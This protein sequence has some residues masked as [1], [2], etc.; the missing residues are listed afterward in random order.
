M[1]YVEMLR[2]RR[3][4]TWYGGII[5]AL[6]AL[7]LALAF[8]D[9][10][11]HIQT[12]RD[13]IPRMPFEALLVGSA[14]GPLIL[15]AFLAVCFDAEYK[16]V[17]IT[18]T[19]PMSRLAIAG[20]YLAVDGVTMLAAWVLTLAAALICI[21]VL[22]LSKYLTFEGNPAGTI[23]LALGCAVMWYGLVVVLTILLPGRG[24]AI[25]GGSWAYVL[26]VP[27]LAQ[28]PFPHALHAVMLALN[29]L[30]PLAYL[31]SISSSGSRT[32]IAGT[33]TMHII[34]AWLIG[35]AAIA[36]G[37]RL[38]ATREVPA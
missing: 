2:A 12:S 10:A 1:E 35:I 16:T 3:V 20:R 22:G 14:F 31:G 36:I 30:N 23:V 19:R 21:V 15:A 5:F 18:W 33:P 28:I 4:L 32:M 29:Y 9:G 7:G 34:A 37:T 25:A 6:L 11:P 8:K 38:W 26:I 13:A 24:N 17:A 27:G